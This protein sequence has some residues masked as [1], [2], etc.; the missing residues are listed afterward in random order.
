METLM[1]EIIKNMLWLQ[2]VGSLAYGA[3]GV[4]MIKGWGLWP[5]SWW[6]VIGGYSLATFIWPIVIFIRSKLLT[7]LNCHDE[8]AR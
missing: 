3:V 8:D 6:W 1:R 5:V 4:A 2:F 7:S